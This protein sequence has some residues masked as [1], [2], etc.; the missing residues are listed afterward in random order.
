MNYYILYSLFGILFLFGRIESFE[1]RSPI[2][3]MLEKE[4][5]KK[6]CTGLKSLKHTCEHKEFLNL[7]ASSEE[8]GFIGYH[9]S[10]HEYRIFQDILRWILE[11]KLNLKIK[12]QFYFF[13]IPGDHNFDH[14][15]LKEFGSYLNDYNSINFLCL[16]YSIYSNYK[17][18]FFS[19]YYYFAY[20]KSSSFVDY[21][22]ILIPFFERAGA[23]PKWIAPLFAI[24]RSYFEKS[25]TGI[26]F[27][28]FD[29]SHLRGLSYY[30]LT[31]PLIGTFAPNDASFSEII[32]GIDPTH[33]YLQTRLLMNNQVTLNP[34]SPLVI[35]RYEQT[36]PEQVEKYEK[37]MKDFISRIE[38]DTVKSN[39]YRKSLLSL[40]TKL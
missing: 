20:N 33:F 30:S 26:I 28:I 13:R 19:T 34:E 9:G 3:R 10:T 21:E 35:K 7:I 24:G 2:E 4:T 12:K 15:S 27:Q 38:V 6:I 25:K 22:K 29:Y 17:N 8:L 5:W 1:Y 11:E 36:D 32:E 40:W 14:A 16:N 37:E 18:D 23:D 39:A 31:D